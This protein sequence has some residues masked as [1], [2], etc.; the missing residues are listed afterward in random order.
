MEKSEEFFADEREWQTGSYSRAN[1]FDAERRRIVEHLPWGDENADEQ[2]LK[3]QREWSLRRRL[4]D[5]LTT[6]AMDHALQTGKSLDE[7]QDLA[8][9]GVMVVGEIRGSLVSQDDDRSADLRKKWNFWQHERNPLALVR[10]KKRPYIDRLS[11]EY[12]ASKYLELPYRSVRV[13]RILVDVLVAIELYAYADEMMT[14]PQAGYIL[15][16]LRSE[17]SPLHKKHVVRGYIIGQVLTAVVLLGGAWLAANAAWN[18]TATVLFVLFLADL[19]LATIGLRFAW[20]EQSKSRGEVWKRIRAMVETYCELASEGVI[21]ARR[22]REVA[23]KAVEMGVAW[24]GPLFAILDD[25]I[26]RTGRL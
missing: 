10:E 15:P 13:E 22:V 3:I 20:R 1:E 16:P 23:V 7:F 19:V 5:D 2:T 18:T 8:C 17:Y 4:L 24:P 6:A 9:A 21:S 25:N 14:P 11:I 12:A 26:A